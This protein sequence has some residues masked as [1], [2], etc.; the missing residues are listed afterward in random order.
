[1]YVSKYKGIF[2]AP[3][4]EVPTLFTTDGTIA[5]NGDVGIVFTG[6]P[7]KQRFYFSKN[8]FW[9]SKPGYPDGTISLVGGLDITVDVLTDA[10]Y[11]T[12]QLILNGT[13][14]ASFNKNDLA[15]R[16]NSWVAASDNIVII[17][18]EGEGKAFNINL[19]LWPKTGNESKTES[20]Q[21][22]DVYW[23]TRKF[24]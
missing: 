21:D 15:Y 16:L 18:L 23:F 19:D 4:Q 1:M 11:Y 17:G 10:S 2:T 22:G 9:R 3:P 14:K 13:I 5:G 6:T 24:D 12:E 7:D 20:G 8:D